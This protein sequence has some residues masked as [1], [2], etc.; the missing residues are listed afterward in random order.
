MELLNSV[1][2]IFKEVS[3]VATA[4][5]VNRCGICD[6]QS[7]LVHGLDVGALNSLSRTLEQNKEYFGMP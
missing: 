4:V 2:I 5:Y 6:L 1:R 3:A 7:I